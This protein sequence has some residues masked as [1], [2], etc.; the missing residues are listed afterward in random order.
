MSVL[1]ICKAI[2]IENNNLDIVPTPTFGF[3]VPEDMLTGRSKLEI[4]GLRTTV[5][6]DGVSA[7]GGDAPSLIDF[8]A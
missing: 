4:L 5:N 7:F 1:P 6:D 8:K 2:F 3:E